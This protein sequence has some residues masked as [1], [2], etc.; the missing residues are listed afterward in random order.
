MMSHND[1]NPKLPKVVMIKRLHRELK[2]GECIDT[3]SF[4]KVYK[5]EWKGSS[6][7]VKMFKVGSTPSI[8]RMN[9]LS[10]QSNMMDR[11]SSRRLSLSTLY[12]ESFDDER[13]NEL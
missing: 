8:N 7:A 2:F 6:V 3:G 4:G 12:L 13:Y 11:K 10:I 9:S 1:Q 5:A